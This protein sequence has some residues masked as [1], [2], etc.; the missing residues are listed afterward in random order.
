MKY[1]GDAHGLKC[2]ILKNRNF[3]F[4]FLQQL[5]IQF[6]YISFI[7]LTI[8]LPRFL[9]ARFWTPYLHFNLH[10]DLGKLIGCVLRM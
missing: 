6:A 5:M 2:V 4:G 1:Q 9:G 7:S 10:I 3:R 8:L